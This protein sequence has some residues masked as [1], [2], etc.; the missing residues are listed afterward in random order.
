M[1][2]C[3]D[4]KIEKDKGE[5]GTHSDRKDGLQSHCKDCSKLRW[6]KRYNSSYKEKHKKLANNYYQKNKEKVKKQTNE[7]YHKN[8]EKLRPS[9]S[10][11][12]K[13][14]MAE[15]PKFRLCRRLRNRLYYALL[16]KSWKKDTRFSKYIGCSL[17]ELRIHIESLFLLGMT[18]ENMGLWHI[19]H[20][21]ALV[22]AQTEEELYKL[23]HYSNLQ[24]LWAKDNLIKGSKS[25]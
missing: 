20:K 2:I 6:Q 5:F 22:S 3:F 17:E 8:K 19:D 11:Y 10:A 16:K 7:Y 9:R 14:K 1:K 21:I 18:W 23:C 25:E 4:C 12:Q 15:D 24:P 13:R